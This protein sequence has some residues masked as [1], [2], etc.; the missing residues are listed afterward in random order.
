MHRACCERTTQP[1]SFGGDGV[2]VVQAQDRQVTTRSPRKVIECFML[3]KM[4]YSRFRAGF[5]YEYDFITTVTIAFNDS[6]QS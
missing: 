2:R 3:I 6:F 5:K 1:Y 4:Y